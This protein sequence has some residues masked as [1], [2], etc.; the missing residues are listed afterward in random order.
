MNEMV[1]PISYLTRERQKDVLNIPISS[2]INYAKTFHDRQF[3]LDWKNLSWKLDIPS[4]FSYRRHL[5]LKELLFT[6]L[7]KLEQGSGCGSVGRAVA[8][9][10]RSPRFESCPW[11]KFKLNIFT[12][13]CIEKTKIKKK[14]REGPILKK[15]KQA[16]TFYLF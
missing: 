3:W 5:S 15:Q 11:Q 8:S 6:V 12:V 1:N 7:N 16:R 2:R 13:N 4:P 9:D 14:G 10:P